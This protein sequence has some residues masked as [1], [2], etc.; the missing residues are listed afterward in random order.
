MLKC[1]A[2]AVD[3]RTPRQAS[4]FCP[5]IETLARTLYEQAVREGLVPPITGKG[6]GRRGRDWR[7]AAQ[8]ADAV[9]ALGI[10]KAG[11]LLQEKHPGQPGD[12]PHRE[13]EVQA[14]ARRKRVRAYLKLD[15]EHRADVLR[16]GAADEAYR[17][18]EARLARLNGLLEH[19]VNAAY[20]QWLRVEKTMDD[21]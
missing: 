3:K 4:N 16:P 1:A 10:E 19:Y 15:E 21:D 17:L 5:G 13:K 20:E 2:V 18:P 9:T 7:V 14:D 6:R 12:L 11:E 8:V